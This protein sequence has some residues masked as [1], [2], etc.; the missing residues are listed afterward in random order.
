MNQLIT[1]NLEGIARLC[2]KHDVVRLDAFGSVLGEEFGDNSDLDFLVVFSRQEETNA[3][4][5][6]FDFKE[7]LSGLLGREVDLICY[8]AIKNPI[9]KQEVEATRQPLYAA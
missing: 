5:Q 1:E 3:F 9:F 6:F 7:A 8:Q 4:H 2:R